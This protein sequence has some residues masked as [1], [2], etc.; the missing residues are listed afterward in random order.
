MP[1]LVHGHYHTPSE[2]LRRLI[3]FIGPLLANVL[4]LFCHLQSLHPKIFAKSLFVLLQ[5]Q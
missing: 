3:P 1:S 4:H 2:D 5:S